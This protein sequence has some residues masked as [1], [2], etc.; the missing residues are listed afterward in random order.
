MTSELENPQARTQRT[1]RNMMKMGAILATATLAKVTPAAAGSG[2]FCNSNIVTQVVCDILGIG[3]NGG[4]NNKGGHG[5]NCFLKGTM[6]RTANGERQI[7]DLAVGDLLPTEFGGLRAVQWIGRYSVKKSDPSKPWVSDALPVRI[8]RSA[9]A[10]N[11]PHAD[12]A[13]TASHSL[14]I[15]GV[16]VPAE[17]LINGGT[18]TRYEP[19]GDE[20]DF[21]H[22]KLESHD[23]VYAEGA[24]AETLVHVDESFINFAD[25]LRQHGMPAPE[26]DRCAPLVHIGGRAELMSRFRSALSPWLDLRNQADVV[27]D[28]VE[29]RGFLSL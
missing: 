26:D 15:D 28:R 17:T 27:R 11:V 1:R 7:E 6:I 4:G 14:L 18:I 23:V 10:P 2:A 12:L 24:P 3:Q 22:I 16:L 19:E 5:S 9:L 8:A 20:L 29:E 13:V 25:Y 21:F